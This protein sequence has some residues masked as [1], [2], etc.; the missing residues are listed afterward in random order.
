MSNQKEK[1]IVVV[2]A[3][4]IK[5]KNRKG[6]NHGENLV[7]TFAMVGSICP[8]NHPPRGATAPA[9]C[10]RQSQVRPLL[11]RRVAAFYF[12]KSR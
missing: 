12:S 4:K 5:I 7:A 2:Y 6:R 11:C 1:K 10:A 3:I 8:S 9:R